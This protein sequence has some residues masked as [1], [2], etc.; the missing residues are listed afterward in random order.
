MRLV[1]FV[2]LGLLA[3]TT[4]GCVTQPPPQPPQPLRFS[5]PTATI[6][7][8]LQDRYACYKDTEREQ[9]HSFAG[10]YANGYGANYGGSSNSTVMPS[11]G[12]FSSC[13]AA[14]GYLRS[15]SG[16]LEVPEA[17]ILRCVL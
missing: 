12:A 11:C 4:A 6:E 7:Q 14:R 3:W 10:G 2:G 15:P 17:A 9:K 8:F 13:L 16:N 5:H 1:T